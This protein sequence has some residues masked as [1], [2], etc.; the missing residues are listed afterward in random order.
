MLTGAPDT[1]LLTALAPCTRCIAVVE[2][3]TL[4]GFAVEPIGAPVLSVR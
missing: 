3:A 2:D 4:S 1:A